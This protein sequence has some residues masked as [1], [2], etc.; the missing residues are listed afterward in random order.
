MKKKVKILV[1]E[2]IPA[3]V[4]SPMQEV[5][6]ILESFG[7]RVRRINNG[8]T[9]GIKRANVYSK[10]LSDYI[11]TRHGR[12]LFIEVK[13]GAD[14]LSPEQKTFLLDVDNCIS[15]S[16]CVYVDKDREKFTDWVRR[17]M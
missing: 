14:T 8:G 15:Y 5:K 7:F 3:E 10:G 4:L 1:P 12:V 13:K 6:K 11:A 9:G 16:T 17:I 2:I